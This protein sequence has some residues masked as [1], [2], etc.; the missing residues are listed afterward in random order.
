MS[1]AAAATLPSP[2]LFFQ[3]LSSFQ[4]TAA[5][6][7]AIEIDL[8]TPL[9]EGPMTAESLAQRCAAS[10]R[11]VRILC[12]YFTVL[13]F[14]SKQDACYSATP[15]CA[16]FLSR[17][18]PLCLASAV[19]FVASSHQETFFK[20]L[21]AAVRKGGSVVGSAGSLEPEHPVWVEFA[22][23]M[24]PVMVYPAESVAALIAASA[25]K[26]WKVLDVAA[27]HGLFGITVARHNPNAE[28]FAVDWPAVL[29]VARENA[30]GAGVAARHRT[31]PGSA[32]DVEFGTGYDVALVTNFLHHFD[33][34][35]CEILLRKVH[36]ALAP[37]G[38]A[39]TVEFVPNE[40]RV[41]PAIPAMFPL[42]MLAST[43][44]GDAYTYSDLERMFRNAG[45]RRSEI[46]ALP[47]SPLSALV[48]TR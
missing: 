39:V 44:A 17:K 20:N 21:T 37:G 45:F 34:P 3:T 8:F 28:I 2:D 9:D 36:A 19:G 31:L 27:G 13:G 40:D 43:P 23:A 35:T 22:R 25:A 29:A 7:A 41:S 6:K 48:S 30:S 1:E 46:H 32:F 14:L 11:G 15:A 38:F 16:M 33:P 42:T 26:K 10:P 24:A 47:P 5:L 18:S 12:D 4:R